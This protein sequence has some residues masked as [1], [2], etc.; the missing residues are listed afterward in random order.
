M[1]PDID[2]QLQVV[3]RSLND[4]I[5]PAIDPEN[6]PAN[7]QIHLCLHILNIVKKRV[8]FQRRFV[9]SEIRDSVDL[10]TEILSLL[11]SGKEA[12]EQRVRQVIDSANQAMADADVDTEALAEHVAL[13]RT[14]TSQVLQELIEHPDY[15]AVEQ[16]CIALTKAQLDKARSWFVDCG[17][18]SDL[19]QVSELD[20]II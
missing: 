6:K 15:P 11:N 18:E 12:I 5:L 9:R 3:L 7:E 13:L 20:K 17:I 19:S 10:L 8:P 16:K 4:I 1:K 2:L 14:T